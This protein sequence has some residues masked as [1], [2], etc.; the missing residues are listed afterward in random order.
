MSSFSDGDPNSGTSVSME[1]VGETPSI[2]EAPSGNRP[3]NIRMNR[4]G[5]KD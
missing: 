1:S 4:Y 5:H 3:F 2:G